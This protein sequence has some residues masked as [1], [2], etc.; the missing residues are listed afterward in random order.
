MTAAAATLQN[1]KLTTPR[2]SICSIFEIKNLVSLQEF[3]H[4]FKILQDVLLVGLK[5]QATE[6]STAKLQSSF[7][8]L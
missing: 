4:F 8:Y 3:V 7:V 2:F 1:S 6:L 5:F